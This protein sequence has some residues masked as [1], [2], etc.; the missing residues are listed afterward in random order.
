MQGRDNVKGAYSDSLLGWGRRAEQRTECW[1]AN[2]CHT[3]RR[4]A[5]SSLFPA[6]AHL[7][8]RHDFFATGIVRKGTGIL[9]TRD[10]RG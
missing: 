7:L 6:V 8:W 10:S 2:S 4:E 1:S 9:P 3:S 5:L